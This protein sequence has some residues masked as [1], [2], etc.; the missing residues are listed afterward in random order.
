MAIYGAIWEQQEKALYWVYR[1]KGGCGIYCNFQHWP[2]QHFSF[3]NKST[4]LVKER[5][6]NLWHFP[7]PHDRV[8]HLLQVHQRR[9]EQ[10]DQAVGSGRGDEHQR[11]DVVDDNRGGDGDGVAGQGDDPGEEGDVDEV[12]AV[13]EPGQWR[14]QAPGEEPAHVYRSLYEL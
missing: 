11:D 7:R 10:H 6:S 5:V 9:L 14:E 1:R 12:H 8:Q 2:F 4:M 3:G 13:A